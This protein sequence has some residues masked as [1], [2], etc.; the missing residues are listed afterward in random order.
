MES[1]RGKWVDSNWVAGQRP[2]KLDRARNGS[3]CLAILLPDVNESLHLI[4][5][6]ALHQNTTEVSRRCGHFVWRKELEALE[7]ACK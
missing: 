5:G 7:A 1:S 6:P 3:P 2:A 4:Y